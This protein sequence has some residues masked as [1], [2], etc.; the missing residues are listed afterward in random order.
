MNN[1]NLNSVADWND[2]DWKTFRSG[3]SRFLRGIGFPTKNQSLRIGCFAEII[4]AGSLFLGNRLWPPGNGGC[5]REKCQTA[6]RNLGR[7]GKTRDGADNC[8]Q[9]LDTV[10]KRRLL[11][12]FDSVIPRLGCLPAEPASVSLSLAILPGFPGERNCRHRHTR[13]PA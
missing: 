5:G 6:R 10:P 11:R 13:I 4:Q 12:R 3:L 7:C 9:P 2:E 8:F 1:P